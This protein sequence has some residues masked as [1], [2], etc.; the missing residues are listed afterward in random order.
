MHLRRYLATEG[1][2]GHCPDWYLV[3]A[4]AKY[5]G[6]AP[7]EMLA[8][9]MWWQDKALVAMTAENEAQEIINK[10]K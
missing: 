6:V 7:W 2:M 10:R 1:K 3:M 4:V 9:P 8:A 5:L